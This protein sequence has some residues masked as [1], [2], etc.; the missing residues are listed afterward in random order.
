MF[1]FH[2]AILAKPFLRRHRFA[3][4]KHWLHL[5]WIP[6][7]LLYRVADKLERSTAMLYMGGMIWQKILHH[8]SRRNS[9]DTTIKNSAQNYHKIIEKCIAIS[10][11]IVQI[12]CYNHPE[13]LN[14]SDLFKLLLYS[15]SSVCMCVSPP[16]NLDATL[17]L[18]NTVN[19]IS[20]TVSKAI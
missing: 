14:L 15:S 12:Y 13:S 3:F 2:F 1:T 9:Y 19:V 7:L 18:L 4:S 11:H 10:L 5:H 20:L 17:I 6:L 8:Y 16:P